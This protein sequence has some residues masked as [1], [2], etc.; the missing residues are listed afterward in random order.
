[1]CFLL[2]AC[3]QAKIQVQSWYDV[4]FFLE[5]APDGKISKKSTDQLTHH[6]GPRLTYTAQYIGGS[7][8][9]RHCP[10]RFRAVL[11]AR[12]SPGA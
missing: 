5:Q 9:R 1:M 11:R 3:T 12:L 6:A 7:Q 2:V 10:T 4:P 8:Q